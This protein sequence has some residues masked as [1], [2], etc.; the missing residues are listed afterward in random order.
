MVL[1]TTDADGEFRIPYG[2]SSTDVY[3]GAE[4]EG[5]TPRGEWLALWY[6]A[7]TD[8]RV[9]IRL[10]RAGLVR[11]VVRRPDGRPAEGADV[12]AVPA[13]SRDTTFGPGP[14]ENAFQGEGSLNPR[15]WCGAGPGGEYRFTDLAAGGLYRIVAMNG[16]FAPSAE[17][18]EAFV[19]AD[20][21]ELRLDLTL[22]AAGTL[23]ATLSGGG[24]PSRV[25]NA[26]LTSVDPDETWSPQTALVR[27]TWDRLPAGRF[28]LVIERARPEGAHDHL[29]W[30]CKSCGAVVHDAE[31]RLVDLGKQLKPILEEFHQSEDLRRCKACGAGYEVPAPKG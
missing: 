22:R 25:S 9:E 3:I 15:R 23:V 29:R 10:D 26:R 16:V 4:A 1:A 13:D 19:P 31:F 12:F 30:Y 11:G 8:R 27:F 6:R 24:P 21:S 14:R 2:R 20:G 5:F 17:G 7:P 28:R 18:R